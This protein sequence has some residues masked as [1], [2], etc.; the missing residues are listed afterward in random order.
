MSSSAHDEKLALLQAEFGLEGYGFFWRVLELIALQ[1]DEDEKN[2]CEYPESFLRKSLGISAKKLRK[3]LEFCSVFKIFSV[4]N[5]KKGI[6][7]TS[8]NIF[9]YRDEWTKKKGKNSGV[10]PEPL[11]SKNRI[12]ENRIEESREEDLKASERVTDGV[13]LSG[14]APPPSPPPPPPAKN[15]KI[16]PP[17]A[18]KNPY[19][20]YRRVLLSQQEYQRLGEKY[21]PQGLEEAIAFLDQHLSAKGQDPY[22][23]H[24]AALQKWVFDAVAEKKARRQPGPSRASPLPPGQVLEGLPPEAASF[25]IHGQTAIKNMLNAFKGMEDYHGDSSENS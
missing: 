24:A 12:E 20:E 18:P 15:K 11:R 23:S 22:A 7:I 17:L 5:T 6:R 21:G 16:N 9:K 2:F 14:S 19:G 1:I 13:R 25:G 4:E 8:A 3:M 10:T